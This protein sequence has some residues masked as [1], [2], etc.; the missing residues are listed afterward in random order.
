MYKIY[1]GII[2]IYIQYTYKMYIYQENLS[3]QYFVIIFINLQT[4][5]NAMS[6][7]EFTP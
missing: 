1:I 5:I 7:L 3:E 2:I 6:R 4:F